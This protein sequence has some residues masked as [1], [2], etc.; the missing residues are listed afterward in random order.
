MGLF[1]KIKKGLQKTREI[2]SGRI[3]ELV[4]KGKLRKAAIARGL[5]E[6]AE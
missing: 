1:D 5:Y 3:D 6:W 4:A 2:F